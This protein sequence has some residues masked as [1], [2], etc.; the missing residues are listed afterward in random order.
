MENAIKAQTKTHIYS[1]Q[2]ASHLTTSIVTG[3][4]AGLIMAVAVMAVFTV[5]GKGPLYPVQVIGSLAL[6]ESALVGT[7]FLAI[8]AGLVL[9]QLGPSLMWGVIFYLLTPKKEKLSTTKALTFGAVISVISMAGPYILIPFLMNLFH[10]VDIW[11]REVPMF[12]D[13]IAHIIFGLSFILYPKIQE[14]LS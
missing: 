10:G 3:Q 4:I 8:L 7:N 11:N 5:L 2:Q 12:W 1:S 9:H 13:W 6:G 14:K